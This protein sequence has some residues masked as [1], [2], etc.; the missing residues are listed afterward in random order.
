MGYLRLANTQTV[1]VMTSGF[2]F[3][4]CTMQNFV[5][6]GMEGFS[7]IHLSTANGERNKSTMR[8]VTLAQKYTNEFPVLISMQFC[9]LIVFLEL[10]RHS[11]WP[12]WHI[13]HF[14]SWWPQTYYRNHHSIWYLP[15][16]SLCGFLVGY[17]AQSE[18]KTKIRRWIYQNR[19]EKKSLFRR[20]FVGIAFHLLVQ[21]SF[22]HT[23]QCAPFLRLHVNCHT[24]NC[25]IDEN[26]NWQ[27]RNACCWMCYIC[28]IDASGV[29]VVFGFMATAIVSYWLWI[30][31]VW[32]PTTF[33][34]I[35]TNNRDGN[36]RLTNGLTE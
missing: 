34:D 23:F 3:L 4:C 9:L 28:W 15:F 35:E 17:S 33:Y 11:M 20:R 25:Q 24:T 22:V 12:W 36:M 18:V 8:M 5:H 32:A 27:L 2:H 29:C 13:A 14:C 7:E 19:R 16:L 6:H 1:V 10:R 30:S 26:K 31:N 21:F